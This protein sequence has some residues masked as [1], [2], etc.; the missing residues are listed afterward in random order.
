[1]NAPLD[2]Q[3]DDLITAEE[4]AVVS[5]R[6]KSSIRTWVRVGKLTGYKADPTKSNSALMVSKCELIAFLATNK[7][8]DKPKQAGRQP[9]ISVSIEKIEKEKIELEMQL[10]I[11][12]E[13]IEMLE[14]FI[15]QSE[16]LSSIQKDA[17]AASEQRNKD[18]KLDNDL[19]KEEVA[20]SRL[21]L[22][23]VSFYL[24]LPWWKKWNSGLPLLEG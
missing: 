17:L 21:R 4:A 8:P 10:K 1:M 23:Q 5:D 11:A 3:P 14:R 24:S 12:Q 2:I 13:K 19:L 20:R 6:S 7:S 16:Q 15:C 9:D 18:I 22:E